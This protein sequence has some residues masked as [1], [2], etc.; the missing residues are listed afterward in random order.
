MSRLKDL[1]PEIHR[2]WNHETNAGVPAGETWEIENILSVSTSSFATMDEAVMATIVTDSVAILDD[3]FAAH[4]PLTPT[5][6]FAREESL[7]S[8]NMDQDVDG[9]PNIQWAADS[10]HRLTLALPGSGDDKVPVQTIAGLKWAP[11]CYEDDAWE[12]CAIEDYWEELERRYDRDF[13]GEYAGEDDPA[14]T[15][16]GAVFVGQIYYL[17]LYAGVSTVVEEDGQPLRHDYQ[18]YDKL[19]YS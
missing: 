19:L 11:Y 13:E 6:L 10:D 18:T 9:T 15:R 2:R 14:A 1:I 5:L 16:E 17:S 7:R 12:A 3:H 8:L 4:T